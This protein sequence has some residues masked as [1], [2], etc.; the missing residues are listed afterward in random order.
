M[1]S[2][3]I[4]TEDLND[5]IGEIEYEIESDG[6]SDDLLDELEELKQIEEE[7]RQY[8]IELDDNEMLYPEDYLPILAEEMTC[9]IHGIDTCQWP[10]TLIDWDKAGNQLKADMARVK[11]Q[12]ET[13]W[14]RV[15]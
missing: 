10:F 6:E 11:Y 2:Q 1:S 12:G 15:Y 7:L 13:Y 4:S 8:G 14:F 9:D 5:R 3:P